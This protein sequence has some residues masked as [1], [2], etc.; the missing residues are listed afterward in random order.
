MA[1]DRD[2]DRLVRGM[3]LALAGLAAGAAELAIA[4]P[5]RPEATSLAW[6]SALI[7]A[8]VV[9]N[10]WSG[11]LTVSPEGT[12]RGASGAGRPRRQVAT[13]PIVL[14][15]LLVMVAQGTCRRPTGEAGRRSPRQ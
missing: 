2:E 8:A 10:L 5:G 13:R 9:I 6:A 7:G 15:G 14:V 1:D 3:T 4:E 11:T 12:R